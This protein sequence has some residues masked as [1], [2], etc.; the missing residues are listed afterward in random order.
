[1]TR[2]KKIMFIGA[3]NMAQSIISGLLKE[4]FS[5]SF[6]FAVDTDEAQRKHL[7]FKHQMT[8]H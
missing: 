2:N 3:G 4:D 8:Y 6:I 5:S 7:P 1:M